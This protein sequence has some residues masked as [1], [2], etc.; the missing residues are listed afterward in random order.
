M[1]S[2][3][4][5]KTDT[6]ADQE[7]RWLAAVAMLAVGLLF[8]ALPSY[9]SVG[10]RWLLL[11]VIAVL[12]VPTVASHRAGHHNLSTALSPADTPALSRWAKILMM[13]QATISLAVIALLAARAVN[14]L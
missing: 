2:Q 1:L 10:P 12:L 5:E 11:L 3:V 7:P 8:G 9:L 4:P 6:V 13:I 14:I